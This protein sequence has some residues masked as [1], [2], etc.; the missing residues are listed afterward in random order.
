MTFTL[1]QLRTAMEVCLKGPP[2]TTVE[3]RHHGASSTVPT[4]IDVLICD[5]DDDGESWAYL[6][7]V[8]MSTVELGGPIARAELIMYVSGK[9]GAADLEKLARRLGDVAVAPFRKPFVL[10]EEMILDDVELPLFAGMRSLLVTRWNGDFD[11]LPGIEPPVDLMRV[12]PLFAREADV[13]RRI[14][15]HE[16][17]KRLRAEGIDPGVPERREGTLAERKAG[18]DDEDDASTPVNRP[19]DEIWDE[20][21]AWLARHAPRVH[22]E[23]R[24]GASPE[25]IRELEETIGQSCPDEVRAWFTRHDG[26]ES[27]G[28]FRFV[29]IIGARAHWRDLNQMIDD[30]RFGDGRA[31]AD[32]TGRRFQPVWWHRGWLPVAED[33]RGASL[34][35]VDLDPGPKGFRGQL[36]VWDPQTG[37]EVRPASLAGWFESFLDDLK[38]GR[39][40]VDEQGFLEHR[41]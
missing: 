19:I 33:S 20:L 13:V 28:F 4:A 35:C 6:A 27:L 1:D 3:L 17:I 11:Q 18:S 24:P 32:K 10:R 38:T 26:A 2:T 37:P 14:G 34:L 21:D 31:P 36:I 23:L 39:E 22:G 8:G 40:Y 15:S 16:A 29:P 7:T 30:G 41:Y 9:H 12:T 25:Q 5:I